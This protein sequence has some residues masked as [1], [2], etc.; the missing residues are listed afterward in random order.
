MNKSLFRSKNPSSSTLVNYRLIF[1]I[2]IFISYFCSVKQHVRLYLLGLIALFFIS[3]T[4]VTVYKHYCSHG[5]V[6][7]GV[8][9]DVNHDCASEKAV[10]DNHACC[11]NPAAPNENDFKFTEECCTSDVDLYQIDT[12]LINHDLKFEFA[13]VSVIA[14]SFPI[15][16]VFPEYIP[17]RT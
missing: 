8:F 13:K 2:L 5:G 4:G 15:T 7:Y 9:L 11:T 14:F 17:E 6:F 10:E 3:T 12:D 16:L 1:L